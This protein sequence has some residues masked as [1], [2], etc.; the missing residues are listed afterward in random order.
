MQNKLALYK[1]ESE[2]GEREVRERER[3]RERARDKEKPPVDLKD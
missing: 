1:P 2:R 3:E